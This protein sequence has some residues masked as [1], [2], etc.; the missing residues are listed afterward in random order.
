MGADET[1][2]GAGKEIGESMNDRIK[3]LQKIIPSWQEDSDGIP[4]LDPA[5]LAKT[6]QE[7]AEEHFGLKLPAPSIEE[8]KT[9]ITVFAAKNGLKQ[10]VFVERDK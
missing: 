8:A 5:E 4:V 3:A 2:P 6:M 10:P 9:A 7:W 1:R